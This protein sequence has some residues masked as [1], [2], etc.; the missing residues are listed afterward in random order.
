VGS[1]LIERLAA[2]PE[3]AAEGRSFSI[4]PD[5]ETVAFEWR[6]GGDWQVYTVDSHGR[7]APQR[8]VEIDDPCGAP[9][10]STDG[11]YLYFSRDD[12]GSECFDIYRYDLA[13]GACENLLPDTPDLSISVDFDLSPDGTR[14]T[15]AMDHGESYAAAVMPAAVSPRG[16]TIRVIAEHYYN[17]WAPDWSPDG[18]HVAFQCDTHGQ[19]AAVFIADADGGAVRAIGGDEPVL[20][21]HPRWS[22]DGTRLAFTGVLHDRYAIGLYDVEL[23]TIEWAW[24]GDDDG[25]HPVWSPDGHRLLFLTDHDAETALRHL[26]LTTDAVTTLSVGRGNH[27]HPRFTPDGAAVLVVLSGPGVPADLFRV[28]VADGRVT[29]LTDGLPDDLKGH[30]FATGEHI[31]YRSLD[32]LTDVPALIFRP[33][34]HNGSGVVIIHGGPTWH[35]SNEWDPLRDAFLDA[36]CM[37][38]H[39]NYRGSDGYGRTWQLANRYLVGQGEIQDVAGAHACLVAQGCDPARI[40]CTGASWGGFHTM[41]LLTQFP[42]LWACGVA[43][44]PFFDFVWAQQDPAVRADLVWWDKENSGDLEKDRAR[45]EYSSP[46]THLQRVKAPL[47][48]LAAALDPRCPP[49]QVDDVA[50]RVRANGVECEAVIYPDEGHQISGTEHRVD[51]AWRTVE[52]ILRH[53]GVAAE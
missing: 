8:L 43:D 4:S 1:T 15:F 46:I 51:A 23:D 28:E 40:A 21:W 35:H 32:L 44:V 10:F 53:L 52:F 13:S 38:V 27:Y 45:L 19:D 47:L 5:G 16:E 7:A 34:E 12:R 29:R 26:D 22:P 2:V 49:N 30:R 17:D 36:G 37:V 20:A 11:R 42:D 48:M 18:R 14:L 24:D 25:H 31:H 33:H 6:Q 50:R 41:S 9:K 3:I 39:P